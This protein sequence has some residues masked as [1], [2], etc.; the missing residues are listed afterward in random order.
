MR[1]LIRDTRV[2]AGLVTVTA[3]TLAG[4][5]SDEIRPM[6]ALN[7]SLERSSDARRDPSMAQGWL[8][9]FSTS[10]F[11]GALWRCA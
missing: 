9:S 2:V 5:S 1:S 6:N 11:K 8:A 3:F 7:G 10:T 4:C